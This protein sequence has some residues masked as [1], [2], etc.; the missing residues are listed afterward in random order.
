MK[1][2]E[3]SD[4]GG[5]AKSRGGGC[6]KKIHSDSEWWVYLAMNI[7]D[8]TEVCYYGSAGALPTR[9]QHMPSEGRAEQKHAWTIH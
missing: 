5:G 6:N 4:M 2:V 7:L 9:G 1:Q 8:G 3:D